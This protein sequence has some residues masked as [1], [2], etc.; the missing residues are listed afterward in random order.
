MRR[1][2]CDVHNCVHTANVIKGLQNK[3]SPLF[4]NINESKRKTEKNSCEYSEKNK[5]II[6]IWE[7]GS[8]VTIASDLSSESEFLYKISQFFKVDDRVFFFFNH[9]NRRKAK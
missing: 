4:I 3:G 9:Y 7:R 6:P 1:L 5:S 8:K 2:I